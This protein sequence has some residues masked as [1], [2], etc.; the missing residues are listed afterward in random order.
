LDAD[1]VDVGARTLEEMITHDAT[2]EVC[3]D[4]HAVGFSADDMPYLGK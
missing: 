3:I 2:D 1:D 4:A